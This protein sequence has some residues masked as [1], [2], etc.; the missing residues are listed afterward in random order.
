MENAERQIGILKDTLEHKEDIIRRIR[1]QV[2]IHQDAWKEMKRQRDV[3][4]AT[5]VMLR[6]QRDVLVEALRIAG[7]HE[8]CGEWPGTQ[9]TLDKVADRHPRSVNPKAHEKPDK[10]EMA[11]AA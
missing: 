9:A 3:A 5:N 8:P 10:E 4:L 7:F 1:E 6:E 11:N 2:E